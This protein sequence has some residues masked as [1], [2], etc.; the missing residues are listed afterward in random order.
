MFKYAGITKSGLS[1]LAESVKN[2]GLE[3][4][5]AE[6]YDSIITEVKENINDEKK[7]KETIERL[8]LDIME[9][10]QNAEI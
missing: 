5:G 1:A 10:G 6:Y 3:F 4:I 9:Y 2:G 7:L 8:D